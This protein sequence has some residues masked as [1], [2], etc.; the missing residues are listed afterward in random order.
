MNEPNKKT[1][2]SDLKTGVYIT[3]LNEEKSIGQVLSN[4]DSTYDAYL[5][6]DGSSDSTAQIALEHGAKVIR[7]FM[8]LGQGHA[9]VTGLKVLLQKDY[10]VIV[11]LDGDGQHDPLEIPVGIKTLL[12]GGYDYVMGSR[13]LGNNYKSAPFLR[14]TFL[15]HFTWA[16]NKITGYSLTDSM[17]GFRIFNAHSLRKVFGLLDNMSEPQY[18][19]AEILILSAKYGLKVGEFPINLKARKHGSSYKGVLRHGWGVSKAII[20]NSTWGKK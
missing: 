12:D 18:F 9:N 11:K 2:I 10:D 14:K 16:I 8:C 5:V 4:I 1:E 15:P 7:H 19:A 20:M 13:I 3:A 6:D 17:T